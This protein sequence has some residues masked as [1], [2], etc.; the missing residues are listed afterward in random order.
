MIKK[1]SIDKLSNLIDIVDVVGSYIPLKKSGSNYV[2]VCPFHDDHS[3]SMHINSQKGFYHCFS[4]K[5]GG[6]SIKFVMEYEKLSYPEAIEKLASMYNFSLEYSFDNKYQTREDKKILEKLNSF[7]KSLLYKNQDA[8]NYLKSRKIESSMIE[9]FELGWAGESQLSLNLL[10]NEEIPL[11]DALDCG[12][13]KNSEKG[14]YASFSHRIT[15]PIYN[16]T[17]KLVGFGGRTISNHPAKYINSPES[18]I[19]NKSAIF[20]AY[21]LAKKQAFEKGQIIITEGYLDTIMLH[22]IGITNAVAVLGTALTREHLP[23]LKRGNLEAILCF[24]GDS[25]GINAAKKSARLLM[26]N[27]IKSKVI[28][29]QGGLDPADMVVN[30]EIKELENLLNS[31]VESGEFYIRKTLE[32]LDLSTPLHKE[33]ALKIVSEFTNSLDEM[34]AHSYT[35]LIA[36]ILKI[37]PKFIRYKNSKSQAW[38]NQSPANQKKGIKDYVELAVLKASLEGKIDISLLHGEI[39]LFHKNI[40]DAIR[41][42]HKN[43]DDLVLLRELEMSGDVENLDENGINLALARLQIRYLEGL[44]PRIANSNEIDKFDKIIKIKQQIAHLKGLK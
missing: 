9:K 28:L 4:C 3:P 13:V 35:P 26:E 24:D 40:Y 20:Y 22:S 41:I 21:N 6:D 42:S 2:C 27:K 30:G 11:Q 39:F 23:L 29:L 18:Q 25:A 38:Q 33:E 1:E 17:G 10:Q 14:I 7:Y 31:G 16:H 44:L 34:I 43:N 19:F 8:I 5:A 12:A 15:F 36:S 32:N 37:D